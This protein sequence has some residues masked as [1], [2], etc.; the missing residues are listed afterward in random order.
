MQGKVVLITGGSLGIGQCIAKT[1]A[2]EGA[3]VFICSRTS[4]D[5][6]YITKAIQ[7]ENEFC[8]GLSMDVTDSGQVKAWV[9]DI[10]QRLKRVD[11][12]INCAGIYGPIGPMETLDPKEWKNT[13][14][15]NL[16]GTVNCIRAVVP[17]MK[18]QRA[19]KIINFSGGGVGGVLNPN[20]S[21]YIASKAGV[22]AITE[23][24]ARELKDFN[25]QVNAIAP[26][27]VNTRFLDRVL[28]AGSNP[29]KEFYERSLRQKE[30]GGTP[31]ELAAKL[32][33]FL[34]SEDSN[35]ITGKIISAK[36]D[37]FHQAKEFR[38]ELEKGG[39]WNLRRIDRMKFYEKT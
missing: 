12:L 9:E 13:V 31:P 24:L 5:V 1:F 22:G 33:L 34:A 11:L 14:E 18:K 4:A 39:L 2:K 20:F 15:I 28:E 16:F 26:G 19:G 6:N 25:I 8:E 17:I 37:P 21:A 36:W 32:A 10:Y 23:V 3:R 35:F 7:E 27:A 30:E 29:G 38:E